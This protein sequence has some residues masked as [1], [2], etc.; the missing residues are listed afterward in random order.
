MAGEVEGPQIGIPGAANRAGG[1]AADRNRLE[2]VVVDGERGP[3]DRRRE[4]EVEALEQRVDATV[5]RGALTQRIRPVHGRPSRAALDRLAQ[6]ARDLVPERG[7]VW[8]DARG[9]S[10]L[11]EGQKR[12]LE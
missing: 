1:L 12:R 7:H 9:Q 6:A 3:R 2:R 11:E 4:Q 5:D 10:T 8:T